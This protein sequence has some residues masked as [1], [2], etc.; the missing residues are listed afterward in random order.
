LSLI[1]GVAN[2]TAYVAA[3]NG[4]Q[5]VPVLHLVPGGGE[6]GAFVGCDVVW[7]EIAP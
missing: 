6:R 1:S 7:Q 4:R 2:N 3:S 5:S